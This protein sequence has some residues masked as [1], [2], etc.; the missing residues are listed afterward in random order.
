[1]C[2][3]CPFTQMDSVSDVFDIRP[4]Y[5]HLNWNLQKRCSHPCGRV[6]CVCSSLPFSL[7]LGK[8]IEIRIWH[9]K[10]FGGFQTRGVIEPMFLL[11]ESYDTVI[12]NRISILAAGGYK[13]LVLPPKPLK[14]PIS[15]V[16]SQ[17]SFKDNGIF[18]VT[19]SCKWL[20]L[21]PTRGRSSVLHGLQT[22]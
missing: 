5:F 19:V 13:G 6:V 1:M 9:L 16:L 20:G 17:P 4:S 15:G 18:E 8:K 10:L 21:T 11:N 7:P 14:T 12:E 2:W 22:H 3:M